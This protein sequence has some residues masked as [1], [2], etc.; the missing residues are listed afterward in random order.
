MVNA[1][2]SP[3]R[4]QIGRFTTILNSCMKLVIHFFVQGCA[5]ALQRQTCLCPDGSPGQGRQAVLFKQ[6]LCHYSAS[7]PLAGAVCDGK[8]LVFESLR[9]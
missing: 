5:S 3:N 1:F 9:Q 7:P 2:Y 8:S 6:S 4:N